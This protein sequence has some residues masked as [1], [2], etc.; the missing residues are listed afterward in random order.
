MNKHEALTMTLIAAILAFAQD[1]IL[2]MQQNQPGTVLLIAFL[3]AL[4]YCVHAFKGG[5][6]KK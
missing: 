1:L 2:T 5:R 6:Q 3:V 4:A